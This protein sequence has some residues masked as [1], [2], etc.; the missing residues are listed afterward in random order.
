M[1]SHHCSGV[2]GGGRHMERLK[3]KHWSHVQ[4]ST[5]NWKPNE[6]L[7]LWYYQILF[8]LQYDIVYYNYIL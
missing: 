6:L 3:S 7:D 8:P 2:D 1:A 5:C 4:A